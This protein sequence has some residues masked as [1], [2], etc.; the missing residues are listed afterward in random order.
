M[1]IAERIRITRQQQKLSQTELAERAGI[2]KKSLSRYELDNSIPPADA[3]KAIADV[4][5]V[6]ADFLLSGDQAQI[7][8]LELFRK[9]EAIQNIDEETKAVVDNFLDLIIRDF[10]ARKA[11]AG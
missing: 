3:L 2:N 7:K 8:D 1:T 9:F 5:G 10:R 6:S 4:L 11:Y